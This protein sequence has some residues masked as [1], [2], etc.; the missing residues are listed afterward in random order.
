MT[1]YTKRVTI[2]AMIFIA[3]ALGNIAGPH[4]FISTESPPYKTGMLA[5]IV[6][7]SVAVP[8]VA[9]L[10]WYYLRENGRRDAVMAEHGLVYDPQD[11]DFEDRTDTENIGF[12]YAL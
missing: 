11:G 2:S 7:F 5:C 8:L 3:Y 4:L 10:R 6:C 9:L 1:G 12:R